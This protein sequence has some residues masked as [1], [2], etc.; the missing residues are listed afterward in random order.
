[1][2]ELRVETDEPGLA[3]TAGDGVRHGA[4]GMGGGEDGA[5]HHYRLLS[6]GKSRDLKTKE[7]GIDVKPGDVF[8]VES[9]GGGGWGDPNERTREQ[10]EAD[11]RNGFVVRSSRGAGRNRRPSHGGLGAISGPPSRSIGSTAKAPSKKESP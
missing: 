2:L 4:C 8:L 10:H 11:A 1:V 5:P 3:N 6:K 9:G 7:V